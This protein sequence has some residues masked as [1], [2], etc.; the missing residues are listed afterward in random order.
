LPRT[1]QSCAVG[2]KGDWTGSSSI[3]PIGYTEDGN[4]RREP[5]N[6]GRGAA[7]VVSKKT[8]GSSSEFK[9]VKDT[10][11]LFATWLGKIV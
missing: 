8:P 2:E 11:R 4:L 1:C 5:R 7:V 6:A 3:V 9:A 10:S